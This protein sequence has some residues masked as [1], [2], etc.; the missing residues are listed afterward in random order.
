ML[1]YELALLGIATATALL[2]V[3]QPVLSLGSVYLVYLVIVVVVAATRGWGPSLLAAVLAFLAA[4]FFFIPPVFTFTIA[5]P[6]DILALVIFLALA[7]GTSQLMARLR[8]EAEEARRHEQATA[9]LY[10]LS[11]TINQ[12][13]DLARLV[14]AVEAQL[15]R[16]FDLRDCRV[17]L[18]RP[19]PSA[20]AVPSNVP[21]QSAGTPARAGETRLPLV[22]GGTVL[23]RLVLDPSQPR[24]AFTHDDQ[25]LLAAFAEQLATAIQRAQFQDA[26]TQA[27]VLRRTDALR[28]AL[29]SA[30]SHDLRTPLGTIKG[31][32]TALLAARMS[33]GDADRRDFLETIIEQADHINRLIGNL[34]TEG[35]IEA[36][37]LRPQK[38]WGAVG[39]IIARVVERLDA[40]LAG[41]P[42]TVQVATDLPRVSFD[43]VEIDEVL[44]NLLENAVK[45][46]PPGT[47]LTIQARQAGETIA[48]DVA[49]AGPGI[50][51]AHLPHLFDRYYRG[52]TNTNA[53]SGLGL[54]IAKDIVEAHG[55]QIGVISRP[56][57]T[58]FTFS[59]PLLPVVEA[60]VPT[61]SGEAPIL[62]E[63]PL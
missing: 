15:V 17:L 37:K 19:S 24:A 4:N 32:A 12:Q 57:G 2:W 30:V 27:E 40:Q 28:A 13:Q 14:A 38:E 62:E 48:V 41:H 44:S 26:A 60:P 46:T 36:G 45:Y 25:R 51:A 56:G 23:G 20:G 16:V 49:D 63:V 39:Q 21:S 6:Q 61:A 5:A 54:A 35:R 43:V 8:F 7:T 58:S 31:A 47:P 9:T 3:V 42:L 50:P 11:R 59:L 22:A 10:Q 52:Q 55:E 53:G 29:L 33:W 1:G 34:L 18:D